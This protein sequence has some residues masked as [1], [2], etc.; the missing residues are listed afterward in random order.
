MRIRRASIFVLTL[1]VVLFSSSAD[2]QAW[3]RIREKVVDQFVDVLSPG[4]QPANQGIVISSPEDRPVSRDDFNPSDYRDIAVLVHNGSGRRVS[5]NGNLKRVSSAFE[6]A[7]IEKGYRPKV[8]DDAALAKVLKEVMRQ[9]SPLTGEQKAE[10]G[11]FENISAILFVEITALEDFTNQREEPYYQNGKRRM[12][13]VNYRV[14]QVELI[15]SIVDIETASTLWGMTPQIGRVER[16]DGKSFD[17]TVITEL[18]KHIAN[19]K[20]PTLRTA[21]VPATQAN[22]TAPQARGDALLVRSGP[23]RDEAKAHDKGPKKSLAEGSGKQHGVIDRGKFFEISIVYET[24]L[25]AI[26]EAYHYPLGPLADYTGLAPDTS[27]GPGDR[28]FVPK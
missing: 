23:G 27:L 28:V 24:T 21:A 20:I 14:S 16:R 12:R 19:N 25:G 15:P 5:G 17:I 9:S 10:L 8:R 1:V 26:A 2:A 4:E 6:M 13:R 18:A 7:L 3:K 22:L 11:K